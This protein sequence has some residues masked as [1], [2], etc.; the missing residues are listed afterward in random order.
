MF[1]GKAYAGSANASL[2]YVGLLGDGS[3]ILIIDEWFE[4]ESCSGNIL[5]IPASTANFKLYYQTALTAWV[6]D[7]RVSFSFSGCSISQ[8]PSFMPGNRT[9]FLL[10]GKSGE[11]YQVPLILTF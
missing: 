6:N 10:A 4:N 5:E 7:G 8:R 1:C 9:D 2:K 3:A 11:E